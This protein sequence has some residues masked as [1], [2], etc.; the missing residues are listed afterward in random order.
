MQAAVLN[1]DNT[2]EKP[3][4][5]LGIKQLSSDPWDRIPYDFPIGKISDVKILK[6]TDFGAFAELVPGVEGLIHISEISEE[7]VDDPRTELEPGQVVRAEVIQLDSQERK[8]G[9]SIKSA[10]R[11]DDLADAQGLVDASAAVRPSATCSLGS[12]PTRPRKTEHLSRRCLAGLPS[13][14]GLRHFGPA[15]PSGGDRPCA[16]RHLRGKSLSCRAQRTA[17]RPSRVP[18]TPVGC[19]FAWW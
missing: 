6:L 13:P 9:L 12:S 2:G 19:A 16:P 8:I 11:Q 15:A 14:A 17:T 10:K 5:S 3:K 18:Q 7:R 1:I 4:I